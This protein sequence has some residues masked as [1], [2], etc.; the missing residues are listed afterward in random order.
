MIERWANGDG[1]YNGV[2]M[3]GELAGIPADE[4]AWMVTRMKQ[5]IRINGKSAAEAMAIVKEEA[6][7]HPWQKS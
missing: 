4:V 7:S 2:A 5:L 6:K 3:L 1:T